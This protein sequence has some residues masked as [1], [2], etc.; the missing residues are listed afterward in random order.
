LSDGISWYLQG[1][2]AK[3]ITTDFLSGLHVFIQVS[4]GVWDSQCSIEEANNP[5]FKKRLKAKPKIDNSSI[6]NFEMWTID[7][8]LRCWNSFD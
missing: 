1:S 4:R 8:F 3:G 2:S 5:Q 7:T 6:I